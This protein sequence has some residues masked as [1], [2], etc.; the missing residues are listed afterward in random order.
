M[1]MIRSRP[2]TLKA[3]LLCVALPVALSACQTTGPAAMRPDPSDSCDAYRDPMRQV[4][5][6]YRNTIA[7]GAVL[8]AVAGGVA[9]SQMSDDDSRGRN[10]VL[11]AIG[12]GILGGA[13]GQQVGAAQREDE[14]M[15]ALA[16]LNQQAVSEAEGVSALADAVRALSNCRKAQFA[17][18]QSR[19]EAGSIPKAEAIEAKAEIDRMVFQDRE[20]LQVVLGKVTSHH[21]DYRQERAQIYDAMEETPPTAVPSAGAMTTR[22]RVTASTSLNV[23]DAPSRSGEVI[24]SLT[25]EEVVV[26]GVDQGGWTPLA[27]D[28][29]VGY[30]SSDYLEEMGMV[31][32][33]PAGGGPAETYDEEV[34]GLTRTVQREQEEIDRQSE[35][36]DTLLLG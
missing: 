2:L 34:D 25:A 29:R 23:R 20:L 4:E 19:V 36:L 33:A 5:S 31:W 12:G 9:A 21:Q 11:G 17:A 8:G 10:T 18:L 1:R 6:N 14:R 3:A 27:Y 28:D 35:V 15:A 22:Y 16:S 24:G 7:L 32:E 26:G 30:A 13:A